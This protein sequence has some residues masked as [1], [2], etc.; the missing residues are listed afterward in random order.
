MAASPPQP[1]RRRVRPLHV[2]FFLPA[3]AF[4]GCVGYVEWSAAHMPDREAEERI[5]TAGGYTQRESILP[6]LVQV[7]IDSYPYQYGDVRVVFL[8]GPVTADHLR[9]VSE[10][11]RLE[12]LWIH[13]GPVARDGLPHLPGLRRLSRLSFSQTDL[14]DADL[15]HLHG[16]RTL[17][18]IYL[19]DNPGISLEGVKQL[20]RHLPGTYIAYYAG[21]HKAG[22][23]P[24][25][26]TH[27]K[28]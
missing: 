16:L 14:T 24:D 23:S 21:D 22:V 6:V 4:V 25:Y 7:L 5:R 13:G 11:D 15:A 9:D 28:R 20:Q 19:V 10:F 18:W 1:T 3:L 27:P 26:V 17:T 8:D 2:L 12:W